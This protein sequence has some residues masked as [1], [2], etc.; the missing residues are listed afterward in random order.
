MASASGIRGNSSGNPGQSL[1]PTRRTV[2]PSLVPVREG[3]PRP[4]GLVLLECL[5][6]GSYATVYKAMIKVLNNKIHCH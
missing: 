1:R 6:S 4:D 5:G 2:T 3:L